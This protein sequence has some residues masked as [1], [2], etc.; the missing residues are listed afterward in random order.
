[1]NLWLNR[2]RTNHINYCEYCH[3]LIRKGH[4]RIVV[5][6]EGNRITNSLYFHPIC[7][8]E[9]I[10]LSDHSIKLSDMAKVMYGE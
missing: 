3:N 5:R 2:K 1:M 7:L 8:L 6:H 10:V 9:Q 4:M